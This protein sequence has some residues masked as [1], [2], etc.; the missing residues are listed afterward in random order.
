MPLLSALP[1]PHLWPLVHHRLMA[2]YCCRAALIPWIFV[3]PSIWRS[4]IAWQRKPEP[5]A[6]I[7]LMAFILVLSLTW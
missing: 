3:R 4:L 7:G 5:A 6:R 1:P 2:R